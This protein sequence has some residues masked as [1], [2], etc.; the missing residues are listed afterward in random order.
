[1]SPRGG[2]S[3]TFVG[4]IAGLES[5][6]APIA[7]AAAKSALHAMAKGLSR[8]LGKGSIRVNT[9]AP[10]NV[11]FAG[12]TWERKLAENPG[13]VGEM[14]E[15]EVPLRRFAEPEEVAN[16]VCFLASPRASFV[17]GATWVVDG[18]QTRGYGG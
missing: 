11:L 7:Y 3:I 4:S 16:V 2:G 10:G 9:V 12:G 18:G 13:R 5:I 17:T 6:G 14:L 15:R 1:M 8:E